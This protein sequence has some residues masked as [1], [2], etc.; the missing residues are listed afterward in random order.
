MDE[1]SGHCIPLYT[2]SKG[3]YKR[4]YETNEGGEAVSAEKRVLQGEVEPY[5]VMGG[6][7]DVKLDAEKTGDAFTLLEI[8]NPPGGGVPPHVHERDDET[9]VL[10]EGTVTALIDGAPEQMSPG[11]VVFIPRGVVHAFEAGDA[12]ARVIAI[13]SPGGSESMLRDGAPAKTGQEP[14][15]EM[16]EAEIG[17][18]MAA[19]AGAGLNFL[20]PA[21]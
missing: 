18:M 21:E 5:W 20:P 19:A 9:V 14:P 13:T 6:V 3:V 11:D 12:G 16:G 1:A 17:A 10:V 7:I 8:T 2:G 15:P 4:T